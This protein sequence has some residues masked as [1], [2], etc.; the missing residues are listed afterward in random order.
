[1]APMSGMEHQSALAY[2]NGFQNG[3]NGKDLISRSGWGL[4]FDFILVHESA[5][6]WFGNSITAYTGGHSWIH[7]GF[8]KY[9]ETLYTSHVFGVEAG[10]DYAVGTW[11][12]IKN[13]KPIIGTNTSDQYYKGSAMLHMIRQIV[14]DSLFRKVLKTMSNDFRNRSV[15]TADVLTRFNSITKHD[16]TIVFDQYLTTTQIPALNYSFKDGRF[17]YR[18]ENCVKDFRMPVRISFDAKKYVMI[19]P[20]TKWQNTKISIADSPALTLDKNFLV[21]TKESNNEDIQPDNS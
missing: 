9:F 12:R 2:G 3:L 11:K 15:S 6:E 18:W 14:G 7:E 4:K 19:Y 17:T 20:S 1:E 21:T 5:H 13:D 10:N 16:F 8:A